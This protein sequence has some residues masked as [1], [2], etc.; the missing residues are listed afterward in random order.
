MTED[1]KYI[2]M[3]G[4]ASLEKHADHDYIVAR[5]EKYAEAWRS[6]DPERIMSFMDPKDLSY[7]CFGINKTNLTHSDVHTL[8]EKNRTD[9]HD[10][11]IKTRSVHGFKSFTAWEYVITF[12]PGLD[13][14]G[15]KLALEEA[16]SEG[17]EKKITGC[18]L[19]WWNKQDRIVR[20]HDYTQFVEGA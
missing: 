10:L 20:H 8:F 17:K 5:Q 2:H 12:R 7:S 4:M 14:E 1:H 13:A 16:R 9:F 6:L 18:T 11:V 3:P 19:M 15:R